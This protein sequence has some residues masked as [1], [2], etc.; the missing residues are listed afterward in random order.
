M[1]TVLRLEECIGG[2]CMLGK[3][4]ISYIDLTS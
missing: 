2:V 4:R 1:N 3:V